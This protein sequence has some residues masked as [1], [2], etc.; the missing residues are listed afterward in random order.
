MKRF[1][2]P[3]LSLAAPL[4]ILLAIVG[5]MQRDGSDRFKA[6]PAL[7]VGAGLILS[8]ALGRSYRRKQ[9][10]MALKQSGRDRN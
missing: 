5:I 3:L 9:L 7:V 8:G 6:L 1:G 10:L 4:L 2:N